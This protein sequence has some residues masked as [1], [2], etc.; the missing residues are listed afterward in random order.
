MTPEATP[1]PTLPLFL[2]KLLK[3]IV[4][5]KKFFLILAWMVLAAIGMLIVLSG[6]SAVLPAIYMAF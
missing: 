2:W 3:E 1:A 4:R 6:T 5:Q